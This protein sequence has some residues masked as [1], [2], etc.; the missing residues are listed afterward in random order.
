MRGRIIMFK[1]SKNPMYAK[2]FA[3]LCDAQDKDKNWEKH[4]YDKAELVEIDDAYNV[5]KL[6]VQAISYATTY[7][8]ADDF[9]D[10]YFYA[11]PDELTG[12]IDENG[13]YDLRHWLPI[14]EKVFELLE[15][16][17]FLDDDYMFTENYYNL[18][19]GNT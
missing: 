8:G 6:V 1:K 16:L 14:S 7:I 2:L 15:T 4:P 10:G 3:I 13:F 17:G 18:V 5:K 11:M 9:V 12:E 19:Y